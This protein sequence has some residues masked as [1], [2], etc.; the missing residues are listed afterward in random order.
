MNS[1]LEEQGDSGPSSFKDTLKALC[2]RLYSGKRSEEPEFEDGVVELNPDS[3]GPWV[4]DHHINS[5]GQ[6]IVPPPPDGLQQRS[7]KLMRRIRR[8]R[9]RSPRREYRVSF[10]EM[11]RM[12]LRKVQ[13]KLVRHAVTMYN[14]QKESDNWETDLAA[15]SKSI[16]SSDV[17][18][19]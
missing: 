13:V 16:Y 5:L 6:E 8:T 10:A 18:S 19:S 4:V 1:G 9:N 12:H 17:L 14:T 15:Y 2:G 7:Q 3:P 11:Q